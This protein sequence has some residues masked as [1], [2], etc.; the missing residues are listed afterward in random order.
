ML[1][2]TANSPDRS[3][4]TLADALQEQ[5]PDPR[6]ELSSYWKQRPPSSEIDRS[7]T[8]EQSELS[9]TL[10]MRVLT[11][12]METRNYYAHAHPADMDTTGQQRFDMLFALGWLKQH[13]HTL[14]TTALELSRDAIEP[15]REYQER[16]NH[17]I[18]AA[19]EEGINPLQRSLNEFARFIQYIA[20]PMNVG[21][22][23]LLDDGTFSAV[24]RNDLW[25]LNLRFFVDGTIKYVLLNRASNQVSG[26]TG[27]LSNLRAFDELS[28]KHG[29]QSL[30]GE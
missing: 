2:S 15:P 14:N 25:R 6:V 27:L 28:E 19:K 20:Y 21:S 11:W 7:A 4:P 9:N 1:E 24:W 22:L 10:V 17:L 5:L 29:L 13:A 12:A 3:P 26:D 30:L 23:F 16:I 18:S 8:Y